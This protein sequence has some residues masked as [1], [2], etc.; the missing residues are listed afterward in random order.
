MVVY[1][2]LMSLFI[3]ILHLNCCEKRSACLLTFF[4]WVPVLI[5]AQKTKRYGIKS[6]NGDIS[7]QIEAGSKLQWSKRA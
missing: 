3:K 6:P 4:L 5:I 2:K 7:V 1:G